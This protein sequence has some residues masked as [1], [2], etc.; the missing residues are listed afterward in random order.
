[1]HAVITSCVN[2]KD[3]NLTM[4]IIRKHKGFVF[5][6]ASLHPEYVKEFGEEEIELREQ[7]IRCQNLETRYNLKNANPS[8]GR[9]QLEEQ[10][11]KKEEA[12][13]RELDELR[14][15]AGLT[16][17]F[18]EVREGDEPMAPEQLNVYRNR[19]KELSRDI[20]KL[21]HEDHLR[22]HAAYRQLT[23]N[24]REMLKQMLQETLEIRSGE[25]PDPDSGGIERPGPH[26][27]AADHR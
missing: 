20:I 15:R 18:P 10:V 5:A 25:F 24:Q 6:T 26:P 11:K 4:Q 8:L 3:F 2:P 22:N 13:E 17:S 16:T 14:S 27:D 12:R 19:C 9:D 7:W 21:I 1:M 23:E